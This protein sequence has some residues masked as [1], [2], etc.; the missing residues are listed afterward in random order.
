[1]NSPMNNRCG[2]GRQALDLPRFFPYRLSLLERRVGASLARRYAE[3]GLDR[4]QWRVLA[5][6]A[7][8]DGITARSIADFTGMDKMQVSRA[9]SRLREAG[10]VAQQTHPR[11]RRASLLRLTDAGRERYRQICPR[12]LAEAE[13]ILSLLDADEREQLQRLIDKLCK[14]LAD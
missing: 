13:R 6:L 1:M 10:L 5:T 3:L 2:E 14:A 4:Q 7:R 9:L 12:V 8:G 11:D